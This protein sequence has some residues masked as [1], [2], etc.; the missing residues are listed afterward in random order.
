MKKLG[1]LLAALFMVVQCNADQLIIDEYRGLN[2][3]E[4][5]ILIHPSL[6]PDMDNV[7]LSEDGLSISRRKGLKYKFTVSYPSYP[8]TNI[9]IA[10]TNL[11]DRLLVAYGPHIESFDR[12]FSSVAMIHSSATVNYL[13]DSASYLSNVYY[14]NGIDTVFKTDGNTKTFISAAPKGRTIAFYNNTCFIANTASNRSRLY[15]S[16][17]GDPTDWTTGKEDT[18]GDSVD[19]ADYGEQIIDIKILGDAVLIL[20]SKSIMKAIGTGNPYQIVEVDKSIGCKSRGSISTY[21]GNIYFLGSDGQMYVTDGISVKN[22]SKERVKAEFEAI[23]TSVSESNYSTISTE[24]EFSTGI[25]SNITT[26]FD[27]GHI[28]F[29]IQVLDLFTDED[30][31]QNPEWII[32]SPDG[33]ITSTSD[34]I[35]IDAPF[36]SSNNVATII[37]STF[38]GTS[39]YSWEFEFTHDVIIGETDQPPN[40]NVQWW[41]GTIANNTRFISEG[42]NIFSLVTTKASAVHTVGTI[43]LGTAP[44]VI[45]IVQN[46]ALFE[47]YLDEVLTFSSTTVSGVWGTPGAVGG[48]FQLIGNYST[49]LIGN[50][51]L[52]DIR[53]QDLVGSDTLTGYFISPEF[54]TTDINS[55]GLLVVN[56]TLNDGTIGH[57]VYSSNT[58]VSDSYL[59]NTAVWIEQVNNTVISITTNTYIWVKS[60]FTYS[61]TLATSPEITSITVNWNSGAPATDDLTSY[62]KDGRMYLGCKESNASSANDTILVYDKK[63]TAWW[64][65]GSG[66]HPGELQTWYDDYLVGSSTAGVVYA[67]HE[68]DTDNG[69]PISAYYDTKVI[70]LGPMAV[71]SSFDLLSLMFDK[72][73]SGN[74]LIDYFI[75]GA[76][77]AD[78]TFTIPLTDTKP[79]KVKTYKFPLATNGYYIQYKI[80]NANGDDFKFH[81]LQTD[82]HELPTKVDN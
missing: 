64:K 52:D 75:N 20:C 21:L 68:G 3:N 5:S 17:Y 71:V 16:V 72:Q 35:L 40:V 70:F 27:P 65:Y 61:G 33:Y 78:N 60:T 67:L 66:I 9:S 29:D 37:D 44:T 11:F 76:A 39:K 56:Q 14:T 8:I 59:E 77:V 69:A 23:S 7:D 81:I 42:D 47:I 79:I 43:D 80:Y 46:D 10:K 58:V 28:R 57:F 30:L 25:S 15:Y 62:W 22:I 38:A 53:Y 74:L 49:P 2:T 26:S 1:I 34:G 51:G 24:S 48:V 73:D 18:D 36:S 4:S 63:L 45:K 19:V 54:L 6:S 12:G 13:W 41:W 32:S 55:W 31:T 82:S 50:L